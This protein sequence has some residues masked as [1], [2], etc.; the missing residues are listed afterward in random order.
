MWKEGKEGG[1]AVRHGRN[2]VNDFGQPRKSQSQDGTEEDLEDCPNFFKKA[3]PCL[4]PYGMGGIEAN[5][6]VEVSF[7]DHIKYLLKY[8]DQRFGKHE[9]FPFMA[10][11]IIQHCQ[12]LCSAQ[13]Q[14]QRK[15]FEAE[16]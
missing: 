6:P 3:Y 13:L 5:Q 8:H 4:F 12:A 11:G 7:T 1:Y 9:T 14:I 15:T 10:F 16:A 2:P